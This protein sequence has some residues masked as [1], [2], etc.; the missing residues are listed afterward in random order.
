MREC[1]VLGL[2]WCV[3]VASAQ[4]P[5]AVEGKT[6]DEW[7]AAIEAGPIEHRAVRALGEFGEPAIPHLVRLL[8]AAEGGDIRFLAQEALAQVG[9]AAVPELDKVMGDGDTAAR[10]GAVLALEKIQG[11]DATP[12]LSVAAADADLAVAIRAHGALLRITGDVAAHLPPLVDALARPETGLRWIAA[13]SLGWCGPL[14]AGSEDALAAALSDADSG[15]RAQARGALERIGTSESKE[16]LAMEAVQRLET[17]TVEERLDAA[18]QIGRAGPTVGALAQR[19]QAVR[20][21]RTQDV[22]VRGYAA[23]ALWQ[24]A[25]DTRLARTFH[26]AQSDGASDDNDGTREHPWRTVSHAAETAIPGDTVVIHEGT[27]REC[28]RPFLGGTD[29]DHLITYR[30]AEGE[31]VVLTG[32]DVWTPAWEKAELPGTGVSAWR[33]PY[34]RHPWDH[35][36]QWPEPQSG[37]MHR[38]EQVFADGRLL[39]HVGT[40]QELADQTD[41]FLTDDDAGLLWVHIRDDA[42]PSDCLI[43]RSMRQQIFAPAVRG[44]GYIRLQGL[45]FRHAANPESNGANWG[46]ISHRAAVSVRTGHHFVMEDC[47]V[48]Y[49]NAQGIDVGG[50]GWG[51]DLRGQPVV[52]DERGHHRLRRCEAT[53][54]GVAGIVGW[55]GAVVDV[56]LEDC[57][58]NYNCLKGNFYAYEAAGVKFHTVDHVIVRRH[59]S[60]GNNAFG[61]WFDYNCKDSR[62]TQCVCTDNMAAGIFYE[63]SPGPMLIDTNIV[64][65]TRHAPEGGWAEG[66]YSHDGNN[67]T[68]ANNLILSCASYGIRLRDLFGRVADGKPTTTSHNRVLNNIIGPCDAGA[69]SLNPNVELA[70]DNLSDRNTFIAED[71]TGPSM[72][73]E[74]GGGIIDWANTPIGANL[75]ATGDGSQIVS[76]EQ[77]RDIVGQDRQS[78]LVTPDQL[79]APLPD[80]VD[81]QTDL[82]ALMGWLKAR[83]PAG[84]V[85]PDDGYGPYTPGPAE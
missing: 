6:L 54:N 52:S 44:L 69:I 68:Y 46:T 80:T 41:T 19:L 57:V 7:V 72:R 77:W 3:A 85:G 27:Y 71:A 50:E 29:E 30:A 43:E 13:E 51:D 8:R 49:A 60:H 36:E 83:W 15:V 37:P 14:A 70:E 21:D 20:D 62:I 9:K 35:P 26:V 11:E 24:V 40:A 4:G 10:M 1:V 5:A 67:A 59:R 81:A 65:G 63:V 38:A 75:G 16:A 42:S 34:E 58:T 64:I 18:V 22:L 56:V 45:T 31:A 33:A 61:I 28:V 17:G 48:T 39:T 74:A 12:M 73:L 32:S 66:I 53:H 79:G 23:W 78:I 55:A 84:N 25:P 47:T 76:Y 82:S 2:L